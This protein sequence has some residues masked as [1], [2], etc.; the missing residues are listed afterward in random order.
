MTDMKLDW[1]SGKT[2]DDQNSDLKKFGQD[3]RLAET[4]PP[5]PASTA[6]ASGAASANTSAAA[7]A[8]TPSA[9]QPPPQQQ[10]QQQPP[11]PPPAPLPSASAEGADLAKSKPSAGA[12]PLQGP[13]FY[14]VLLVVTEFLLCRFR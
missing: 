4:A 7:V 5:P 11:P 3:F 10:Q 14:Q 13:L 8:P 2:R 9:P 6:A 12:H 1:L